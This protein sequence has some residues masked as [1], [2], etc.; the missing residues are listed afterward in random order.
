MPG[1]MAE[2]ERVAE[3]NVYIVAATIRRKKMLY[4]DIA[5]IVGEDPL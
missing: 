5:V 2:A 4:L 1:G 3:K